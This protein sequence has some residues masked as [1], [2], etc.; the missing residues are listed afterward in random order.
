MTPLGMP[1]CIAM[2]PD[3]RFDGP[4]ASSAWSTSLHV[5]KTHL[6]DE[7]DVDAAAGHATLRESP[8]G[9]LMV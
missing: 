6:R 5:I 9:D 7:A 2:K 8:T 1:A 4:S 3:W